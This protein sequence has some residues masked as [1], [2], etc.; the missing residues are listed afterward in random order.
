M[1]LLHPKI[2]LHKHIIL[3]QLL[4]VSFIL[5]CIILNINEHILN[6]T[7]TLKCSEMLNLKNNIVW[8]YDFMYHTSMRI[9]E[10]WTKEFAT[11]YNVMYYI[12][13]CTF[14]IYKLCPV[15]YLLIE[16]WVSSHFTGMK[17]DMV[18]EK[19]LKL[20]CPTPRIIWLQ[21]K[22]LKIYRGALWSLVC[23]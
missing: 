2:K 16:R 12:I 7:L 8:K 20:S 3:F 4:E 18:M 22:E 11:I 5:I 19:Y 10:I 13:V 14:K 23:V 1:F 17:A 21:L 15:W 9:F 6:Y